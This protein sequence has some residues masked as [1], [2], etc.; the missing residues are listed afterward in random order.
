MPFVHHH[1]HGEEH[2]YNPGI[3]EKCKSAGVADPFPKIKE[4]HEKLLSHLE[5]LLTFRKGI[6]A[7]DGQVLEEFKKSMK[8]MIEFMEE[9]LAE[10]ERD[11]PKIFDACKMTQEEEGALVHKIL[12]SLGLDGTWAVLILFRC[13][14]LN[15]KP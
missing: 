3:L 11:Y 2:I 9:H 1:H 5:S 14:T 12:E 10:E 6:D 7:G 4:D 13:S 8:E 15:P